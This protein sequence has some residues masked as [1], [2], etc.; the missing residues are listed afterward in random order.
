MSALAKK[1]EGRNG[2]LKVQLVGGGR[3]HRAEVREALAAL[4]DPA[5]NIL[6]VEPRCLA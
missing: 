3:E 1:S 5:L 4:G 6:E 2:G